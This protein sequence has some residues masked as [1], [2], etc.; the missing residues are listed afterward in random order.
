MTTQ[1]LVLD[2]T[3][4]ALRAALVEVAT[5]R[6][7][8]WWSVTR[9]VRATLPPRADPDFV[10]LAA[11]EAVAELGR[12]L[13]D[14]PRPVAITSRGGALLVAAAGV[15]GKISLDSSARAA[16]SAGATVTVTFS[17]DDGRLDRE[18]R[19]ALL[20]V[21]IDALLL[22]GGVPDTGVPLPSEDGIPWMPDPDDPDG[23]ITTSTL[24]TPSTREILP[25]GE[26]RQALTMTSV[27][28]EAL[29]RPRHDPDAPFPVIFAGIGELRD[30]V[31]DLFDEA[32]ATGR[33]DLTLAANVRPR[34]DRENPH[35]VLRAL[36]DIFSRD[37]APHT[38]GLGRENGC[39]ARPAGYVL[40]AVARLLAHQGNLLLVEM[41][42]ETVE[43]HSVVE[44][45]FNRT[46]S[47][48]LG[49]AAGTDPLETVLRS[50]DLVRHLT[51]GSGPARVAN[52]SDLTGRR[53]AGAH[54]V[55]ETR[56]ELLVDH[57]L[58]RERLA[59]AFSVHAAAA[60]E[61]YGLQ[62]RRVGEV[63]RYVSPS[64]GDTLI[65]MDRFRRIYLTGEEIGSHA[66]PL[67]AALAVLDTFGPVGITL[68]AVDGTNQLRL[69]ATA[70]MSAGRM[71][72]FGERLGAP[73]RPAPGPTR[74]GE[75]DIGAVRLDQ[76]F[77]EV[78]LVIAPLAVPG[79]GPV[80]RPGRTLAE[81]ELRGDQTTS[82]RGQ[83]L[84]GEMAI[85]PVPEDLPAPGNRP[86]VLTVKP[87]GRLDFGS[88]ARRS[89]YLTLDP[90]VRHLVLD[91]RRRVPTDGDRIRQQVVTH[92]GAWFRSE[93]YDGGQGGDAS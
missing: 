73:A 75:A 55:A 30:E 29:P 62:R 15:M 41:G 57:A 8:R 34:M 68:I 20:E 78:V 14:P 87:A 59:R 12:G 71:P 24:S 50:E 72:G 79:S 86:L 7:G 92:A 19:A 60:I 64:G 58:L 49:R 91:G 2:L 10:R 82:V 28:R 45:V 56:E 26:G 5:G 23:L 11:T 43:I 25:D 77:G 85:L 38:T 81:L 88:G 76:V 51:S 6:I 22:A 32:V 89:V 27:L 16:L 52:L 17:L 66:T 33:A 80:R 4:V 69:A 63:F 39:W 67:Q 36:L 42:R 9:E 90:R 48:S 70:A 40:G 31:S 83:V 74:E 84:S 53:L 35:E 46:V 65:R 13:D 47:D 61:L 18:K 3:D 93:A 21:P 54:H 1:A 37:I 44:G